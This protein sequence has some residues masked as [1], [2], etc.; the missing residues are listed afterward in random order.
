M[1]EMILLAIAFGIF[2]IGWQLRTMNKHANEFIEGYVRGVQK[3]LQVEE[4]VREF[5][6]ELGRKTTAEDLPA[7][8]TYLAK[9]VPS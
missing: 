4:T 2:W 3:R 8:E 5:E 9:K 6:K 1:V 7:F